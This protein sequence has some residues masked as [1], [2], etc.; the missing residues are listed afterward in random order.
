MADLPEDPHL[1]AAFQ[2]HGLRQYLRRH[3]YPHGPDSVAPYLLPFK[4][5]NL[6]MASPPGDAK[7]TPATQAG[8]ADHVHTV[9]EMSED[10]WR[11]F[12]ASGRRHWRLF[13]Q[14]NVDPENSLVRDTR[15][16]VEQLLHKG[17]PDEHQHLHDPDLIYHPKPVHVADT[18]H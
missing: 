12:L 18:A 5:M 9:A 11:S 7:L 16:I 10:A 1:G 4:R 2:Q 14:P 13:R 17:T 6:L 8:I 3:Y 15:P